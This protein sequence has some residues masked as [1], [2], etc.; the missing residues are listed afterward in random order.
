MI[1]PTNSDRS[2]QSSTLQQIGS[3]SN[4]A[5]SVGST[6][7]QVLSALQAP[8]GF[9]YCTRLLQ[10]LSEPLYDENNNFFTAV[11]ML[12]NSDTDHS[13]SL[14]LW[15][16]RRHGVPGV[17]APNA[18]QT[19]S[20][21]A[22]DKVMAVLPIIRMLRTL[23]SPNMLREKCDLV[24]STQRIGNPK[25]LRLLQD[26]LEQINEAKAERKRKLETENHRL[27]GETA[28]QAEDSD[29]FH[30]TR[31]ETEKKFGTE[32]V[33]RLASAPLLEDDPDESL[34]L[35]NQKS[36]KFSS[37]IR[38]QA[39]SFN[40]AKGKP[41]ENPSSFS[42]PSIPSDVSGSN[43]IQINGTLIDF[44]KVTFTELLQ[45]YP[46][47]VS[48]REHPLYPD[49]L[50]K[51][52]LNHFYDGIY[53]KV[54]Y[55]LLPFKE[56]DLFYNWLLKVQDVFLNTT[57]TKESLIAAAG[58]VRQ[59]VATKTDSAELASPVSLEEE[60]KPPFEWSNLKLETKVDDGR[61][62]AS[63]LLRSKLNSFHQNYANSAYRQFTLAYLKFL[64]LHHP[65]E[66]TFQRLK[67]VLL[68]ITKD[69]LKEKLIMYEFAL[70]LLSSTLSS[71]L[72]LDTLL[73][74][75]FL[76]IVSF[77]QYAVKYLTIIFKTSR[78]R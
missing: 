66:T 1:L 30:L 50:A 19:S 48:Q 34:L 8:D 78:T 14:S 63:L 70:F 18:N 51:S 16:I 13:Y 28:R 10:A 22:A 40:A 39:Y 43:F 36:Q 29:E 31:S 9:F 25:L 74:K 6:Q 26:S 49:T 57:L 15:K 65:S 68:I 4:L 56:K 64:L 52:F 69:E 20:L 59:A 17:L 33:D 7:S 71:Y 55:Q 2:S 37:K 3:S 32:Y 75:L 76:I 27:Q 11:N 46:F 54:N 62:L 35:N 58:H 21:N 60:N 24:P 12:K 41:T 61:T 72:Q 44:S 5:N 38:G 73:S 47:N 53:K 45:H 23:S 77:N 67:E 42:K